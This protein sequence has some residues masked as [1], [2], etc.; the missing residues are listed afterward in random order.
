MMIVCLNGV[1][2]TSHSYTFV[3]MRA[4]S[5]ARWLLCTIKMHIPSRAIHT[6]PERALDHWHR[7]TQPRLGRYICIHT[8]MHIP[9]R[10][11][12][13]Y[14]WLRLRCFDLIEIIP[15][16]RA[17]RAN[18]VCFSDEMIA[19]AFCC[20]LS[21]CV[22]MCGFMLIIAALIWRELR[23]KEVEDALRIGTNTIWWGWWLF[24]LII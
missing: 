24:K 20:D 15:I 6:F 13:K 7:A 17:I 1:H 9:L 4:Q 22:C 12:H 18:W 14:F 3:T 16:V 8:H 5:N 10:L 23:F 11:P 2:G 21:M 19:H